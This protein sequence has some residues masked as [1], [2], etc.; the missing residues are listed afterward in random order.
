VKKDGRTTVRMTVPYNLKNTEWV[1]ARSD[2]GPPHAPW[3]LTT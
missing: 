1:V 2:E 3:L